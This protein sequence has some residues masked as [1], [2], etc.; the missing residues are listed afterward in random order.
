MGAGATAAGSGAGVHAHI[1]LAAGDL[2]SMDNYYPQ[3]GQQIQLGTAA[4]PMLVYVTAIAVTPGS[5]DTVVLQV[6]PM[7]V[8]KELTTDYIASGK[9]GVYAPSPLMGVETDAVKGHVRG[10][11]KFTK[12]LQVNKAAWHVGD[13][14]LAME[15]WVDVQG[16]GIWHRGIADMERDL[17]M[18]QE[19][20]M[21]IG[22]ENSN[23]T[24]I[25]GT[26]GLTGSAVTIYGTKG[27]WNGIWDRGKKMPYTDATDWT[28][29]TFYQVKEYAETVGLPSG[30][31]MVD[32]GGRFL[33]RI[34]QNCKTYITGATGSLSELFT[35][36]A[37]GGFKNLEVGFKHIMIGDQ[38][39]ILK[40][41][42]LFNNPYFLGSPTLGFKDAAVIYPIGMTRDNVNGG[43]VPNLQLVYRGTEGYHQRKRNIEGFGGMGGAGKAFGGFPTVLE[44]DYTKV[45]ALTERGVNFMEE[46]RG[47]IAYRT[48]AI[49]S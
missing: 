6:S 42:S 27:I 40:S 44:G 16:K 24:P 35:P 3:V 25:V 34:E 31:W 9:I 7:D 32:A 21:Y 17:D 23:N 15:K 5:P 39:F 14:T 45:N 29:D 37:G 26:S 47:I 30:E 10:T 20:I 13:A 12:Y 2:D 11:Q 49:T 18:T 46:W 1:Q 22:E 38:K 28:M 4:L 19:M 33:T 36:L 41:N 8:L 48:D 43:F